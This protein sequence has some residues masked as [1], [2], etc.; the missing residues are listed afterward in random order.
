MLQRDYIARL[1]REFMAA[2]QR[3]VE[4]DEIGERRRGMEELFRQ[5]FGEY[6]F[7]HMTTFDELMRS[8]EKYP[9]EE[10]A[11]RI[12]MLAELY[13][14]EAD[15]LSEPMRTEQL[16]LSFLLFDYIDHNGNT[17]SFDRQN[18]MKN[19]KNKIDKQN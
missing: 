16:R 17:L 4:K 14:A 7:Y 19:I 18:K 15:M 11:N 3:L 1:I 5:Y 13:Y 9:M 6:S 8:F 10:R 12:E 2:L